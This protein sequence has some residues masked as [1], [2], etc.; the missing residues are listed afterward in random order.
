MLNCIWGMGGLGRLTIQF[1]DEVEI[2]A[3]KFKTEH[4]RDVVETYTW[5]KYILMSFSS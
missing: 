2:S 4:Q 5:D 1:L 3:G